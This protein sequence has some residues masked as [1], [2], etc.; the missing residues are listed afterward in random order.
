MLDSDL[1]GVQ[2]QQLHI[3]KTLNSSLLP[4]CQ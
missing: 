1:E 4:Y 3:L 2:A